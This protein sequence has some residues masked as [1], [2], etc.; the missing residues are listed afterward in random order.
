MRV[1]GGYPLILRMASSAVFPVGQRM[2]QTALCYGLEEP[3]LT[4]HE[5]CPLKTAVN[6]HLDGA[7][8]SHEAV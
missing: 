3:N 4:W 2:A 1:H 6:R 5:I 7:D 8:T